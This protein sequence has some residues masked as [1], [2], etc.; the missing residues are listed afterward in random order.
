MKSLDMAKDRLYTNSIRALDTQDGQQ[1]LAH[2]M[3][4]R[5]G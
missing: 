5:R 2:D 4:Q 1:E 3:V